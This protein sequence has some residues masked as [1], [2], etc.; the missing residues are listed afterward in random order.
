[1]GPLLGS[2]GT[3]VLVAGKELPWLPP[4]W[5]GFSY[6]AIERALRFKASEEGIADGS[7][8]SQMDQ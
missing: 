4:A 6:Y 2:E 8:V 1:M 7:Q 3:F 5:S